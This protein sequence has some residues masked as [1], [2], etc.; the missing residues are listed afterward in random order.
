[1]CRCAQVCRAWKD[2]S[3]D[4]RLWNK[5][6]INKNL[7]YLKYLIYM[8]MYTFTNVHSLVCICM[9]CRLICLLLDTSKMYMYSELIHIHCTHIV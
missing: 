7:K 6:C 3:E 5:V 1:M 2:M 4:A 9:Y 8:Y